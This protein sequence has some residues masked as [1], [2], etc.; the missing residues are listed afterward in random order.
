MQVRQQD[1]SPPYGAALPGGA[2]APWLTFLESPRR[3]DVTLQL[4]VTAKRLVR[5]KISDLGIPGGTAPRMGEDLSGA[6]MYHHAKFHADRCHRRR[7]IYNR[8]EKNSNQYTLPYER[9][10]G[11]ERSSKDQYW[12]CWEWDST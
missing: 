6:D 11:N 10:A 4:T 1:T 7:D 12:K 2:T 8:T 5:P 3:A 9:M